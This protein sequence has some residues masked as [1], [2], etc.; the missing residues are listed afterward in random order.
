MA[1]EQSLDAHLVDFRSDVYSLGCTLYYLLTGD[2]PYT[3]ST[4][5]KIFVQHR[6]AEIPSLREQRP[7]VPDS[8][9][10]VFRKNGRQ[11]ARRSLSVHE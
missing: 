11:A 8:I 2:T 6:E 5:F 9:E 7:D 4:V 10:S 1:P 3:G